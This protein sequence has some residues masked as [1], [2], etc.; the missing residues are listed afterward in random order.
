MPKGTEMI[1]FTR[2]KRNLKKYYYQRIALLVLVFAVFFVHKSDA[3]RS[4]KIVVMP[5]RDY[6]QMNMEEMVPDVLRSIFTQSGYFEPVDREI[7]YE[8]VSTAIPSDMIKLENVTKGVNGAWTTDQVDMMARLDTKTVKK[9]GRQLKAD[10]VLKGNISLIGNTVRIDSELIRVQAKKTV[11]S[12][13]VEGN[14]EELSSSILKELSVKITDFCRN[15]NAYDDA[16]NIISLY[17]QG[18]YT[19]DVSEKKLNEILS[20]ANDAVGIRASLMV[21]YLSKI[22]NEE[23]ALIEDKVIEEGVK[24]LMHLDQNYDENILKVFSTSGIDPFDEIARILSKRGENEKAIEVYRKAISVYPI[25]IAKHY[26]ELGMLHLNNGSE[27]K[28]I[29]AFARSLGIHKGNYEVNSTLVSIF[30]KRSQ[31]DKVRKHLKECIKYARNIKEI[32]AAKEKID[33]LNNN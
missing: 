19:F 31:S 27:D 7:I 22:R 17:N 14:H 6:A 30:E 32:K 33:R 2:L 13:T 1:D 5:F 10:Y 29:E 3:A 24:I 12:I 20:L 23:N 9:F 28:A 4:Y 11:V 16:L 15:I 25:H 21:L 8:K 18:Q 26:E